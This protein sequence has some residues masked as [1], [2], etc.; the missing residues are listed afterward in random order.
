MSKTQQTLDVFRQRVEFVKRQIINSIKTEKKLMKESKNAKTDN[1]KKAILEK[2]QKAR[3]QLYSYR[4]ALN[5]LTYAYLMGHRGKDGQKI[6]SRF[7][8]KTVEGY[9]E[10][11]KTGIM[12]SLETIMDLIMNYYSYIGSFYKFEYGSQTNVK[13]NTL[14]LDNL[15]KSIG[16]YGSRNETQRLGS[17]PTY[18]DIKKMRDA[19]ESGVRHK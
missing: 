5:D 4:T 2:M 9:L 7:G 19:V 14:F 17:T 18:D 15:K 8:Y 6:V 1:D 3:H 10:D 16:Q 12:P 11:K 13:R